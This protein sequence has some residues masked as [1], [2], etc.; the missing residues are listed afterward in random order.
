MEAEETE[1]QRIARDLHD[2]VG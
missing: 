1:R 2:G